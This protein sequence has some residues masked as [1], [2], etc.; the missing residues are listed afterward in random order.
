[1]LER[2]ILLRFLGLIVRVLRLEVSVYNV[3]IT[4]TRG[5]GV[6]PLVDV[7]V[8]S[9]IARRKTLF[10][11]FRPRIQPQIEFTNR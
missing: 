3:Y 10:S 6:N 4:I 7:T 8:K 9:R 1:M 11:Q 2:T 5:L